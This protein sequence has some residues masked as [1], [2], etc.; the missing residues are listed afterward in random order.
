MTEH[1]GDWLEE[2]GWDAI[3]AREAREA[4]EGW[5]QEII[6]SAVVQHAQLD[7]D[8]ERDLWHEMTGRIHRAAAGLVSG[9]GPGG[10]GGQ[11]RSAVQADQRLGGAGN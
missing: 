5:T 4:T 7:V 6:P 2:P 3:A 9:P 8:C 10:G 1:W 11:G